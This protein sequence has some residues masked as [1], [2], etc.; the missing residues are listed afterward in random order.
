MFIPKNEFA[1]DAYYD[2]MAP[3]VAGMLANASDYNLTDSA[4][5]FGEPIPTGTG[6]AR[7]F[8]TANS[9]V[10]GIN[11]VAVRAPE[12][13]TKAEDFAGILVSNAVMHSSQEGTPAGRAGDVVNYLRKDRVGG[14]VWV[15]LAKG[16]TTPG[17]NA[18]WIIAP[19]DGAVVGG[20]SAEEISTTGAATSGYLQGATVNFA[21]LK[22]VEK[23]CLK[24]T[25]DESPV[26][27]QNLNF[28]ALNTLDDLVALLSAELS[29]I[30][31]SL[32]G[33]NLK[34][35]SKTTGKNSKVSF[36]QHAAVEDHIDVG[37]LL[38]LTEEAGAL[39]FEGSA[40]LT[41]A[42]VELPNVKFLGHFEGGK[43]AIALVEIVTGI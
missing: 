41:T 30:T 9:N 16:T 36:A 25:V 14:R 38:G 34:L 33:A 20:F 18:H 31:V 26:T 11:N 29:E 32:H 15:R 28:S 37:R 8:T 6:V 10:Q 5:V 35:T 24:L 22:A 17:A 4:F 23:G 7:Q 39:E 3:A 12:L 19:V 42:T 2:Q 1:Q 43:N 21:G 27:L 40:T 13:T